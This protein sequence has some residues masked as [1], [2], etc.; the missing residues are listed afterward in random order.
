MTYELM[1]Y[2]CGLTSYG[3]GLIKGM[4]MVAFLTDG[5]SFTTL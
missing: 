5:L 2:L 3:F 1:K 4:F